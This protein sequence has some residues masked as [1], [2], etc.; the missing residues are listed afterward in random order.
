MWKNHPYQSKL[1][2]PYYSVTINGVKQQVYG[3]WL[4]WNGR[5][6]RRG[7]NSRW[8]AEGSANVPAM[9]RPPMSSPIRQASPTRVF[10]NDP[11]VITLSNVFADAE[12]LPN[13]IPKSN[14]KHALEN[15]AGFLSAIELMNVGDTNSAPLQALRRALTDP[16]VWVD[17][18]LSRLTR[19]S[20]SSVE[21][22]EVEGTTK[23]KRQLL[24]A[25]EQNTFDEDL[26]NE[27]YLERSSNLATDKE[28]VG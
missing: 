7:H 24:V 15:L 12:K 14:S 3:G 20:L 21:N 5:P 19:F 11:K 1:S 4:H 16:H 23:C 28:L 9:A 2:R 26:V 10:S 22:N 6:F 17:T 13:S 18:L 25:K 8:R 27:N